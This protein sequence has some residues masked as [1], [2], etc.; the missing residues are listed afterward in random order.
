VKKRSATESNDDQNRAG[1]EA[2]DSAIHP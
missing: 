2:S 1:S